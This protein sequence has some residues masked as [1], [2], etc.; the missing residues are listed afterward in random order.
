MFPR[1]KQHVF[2]GEADAPLQCNR[3]SVLLETGKVRHPHVVT[4]QQNMTVFGM[5]LYVHPIDFEYII[6]IGP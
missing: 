3:H 4:R 1:Q 5:L 6:Q 2:A